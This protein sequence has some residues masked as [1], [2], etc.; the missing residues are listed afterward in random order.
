M[1]VVAHVA[2]MVRHVVAVMRWSAWITME[3][4][5]WITNATIIVVALVVMAKRRLTIVTIVGVSWSVVACVPVVVARVTL[6]FA[7]VAVVHA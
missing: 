2:A 5:A 4:F 3:L 6:R 7:V 1:E